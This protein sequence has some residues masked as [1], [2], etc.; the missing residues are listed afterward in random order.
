MK[1]A[2]LHSIDFVVLTEIER[3]FKT[4]LKVCC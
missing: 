1:N 2:K 3:D 4:Q